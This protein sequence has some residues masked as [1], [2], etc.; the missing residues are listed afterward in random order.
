MNNETI[1]NIGIIYLIFAISLLGMGLL[2]SLRDGN[3]FYS[4]ICL[5]NIGAWI[6]ALLFGD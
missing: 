2:A 5:I 6:V 1:N 4:G 3:Y